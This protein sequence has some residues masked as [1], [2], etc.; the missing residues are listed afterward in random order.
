MSSAE[1]SEAI[2]TMRSTICAVATG[3]PDRG[4]VKFGGDR[5]FP[6][7]QRLADAAAL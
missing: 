6:L 1:S 7:V 5:V 3:E 4:F 2:S